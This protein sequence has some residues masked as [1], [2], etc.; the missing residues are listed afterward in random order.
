MIYKMNIINR[1]ISALYSLPI[2]LF[3]VACGQNGNQHND[4][5]ALDENGNQAHENGIQLTTTQI[6]LMDIQFGDFSQIKLNDYVRA[7]GTLGLPPNAYTSVNAKSTGFIQTSNKYVEGR[8]VKKEE[9]IGYL[10]NPEFIQR[11]QN[12]LEIAAELTYLQQ[13][14]N[15]QQALVDKEA[16]VVQKVQKL[17]AD[18]DMK[19]ARLRGIGEQ[20]EYLGISTASLT[21]NNIT[22]RIAIIAPMA[23]YITSLNMHAGMYV[24]PQQAL[25]ELISE[26]HLHLELDIF[27]KDI[28][29]VREGQKITYIVPSLGS[30]VY[31]G[32]VHIIGKEFNTENKTVR[33]HGHLAKERPR[34]IKDL[35]VDAKIWLN[36]RTVDALPEK[37]IIRD[38][39][40]SYI[41]VVDSQEGD[42]VNFEKVMV[43]PS[44]RDK[45]FTAVKVLDPIAEGKQIVTS[46]AYFVH[47]E[48]QDISIE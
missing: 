42:I 1:I 8:Y 18:V 9:V 38:G 41:F 24:T 36:D 2:L 5:N 19:T 29:E 4:A 47:A 16:G 26:R 40:M 31:E 13:Q 20:L 25:M 37:A 3:L 10:E 32:N 33:V 14:L 21:P 15:R 34:F 17:Q 22:K 44:T 45:G 30:T 39:D 12:Y 11:Q 48:S 43:L 46:G 28:A 23:G 6:D 7:T 27:E 35:F